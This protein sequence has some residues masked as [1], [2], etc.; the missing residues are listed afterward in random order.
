MLTGLKEFFLVLYILN[1]DIL[2]MSV[3]HIVYLYDV[4]SS[5]EEWQKLVGDDENK[6]LQITHSRDS[7]LDVSSPKHGKVGSQFFLPVT[8][9]AFVYLLYLLCTMYFICYY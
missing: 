5:M 9:A 7:G 8:L 3:G 4:C 6:Q 1:S 2:A